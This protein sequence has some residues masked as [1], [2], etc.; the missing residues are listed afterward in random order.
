MLRSEVPTLAPSQV[1]TLITSTPSLVPSLQEVPTH[2][3]TTN[4]PASNSITAAPTQRIEKNIQSRASF[5]NAWW[6][7][8]A[9]P[10]LAALCMARWCL[11]KSPKKS[12]N[13]SV[14]NTDPVADAGI[15]AKQSYQVT[16][17]PFEV[18]VEDLPFDVEVEDI[19]PPFCVL[20][21]VETEDQAE[22]ASVPA[23]VPRVS[24]L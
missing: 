9:V 1:L 22:A 21:D 8:V 6:A 23:G 2:S 20:G 11:S 16:N 3:P 7:F 19:D 17:L 10:V 13:I 14:Q 15:S 4:R 5:A 12:T 24:H 18:E